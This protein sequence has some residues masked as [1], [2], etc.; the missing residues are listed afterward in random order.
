[1][2][3][4]SGRSPGSA[5]GDAGADDDASGAPRPSLGAV[6]GCDPPAGSDCRCTDEGDVVVDGNGMADPAEGTPDGTANG[7]VG[8]T[9]DGAAEGTAGDTAEGTVGDTVEGNSGGVV[10]DAA[11]ERGTVDGSEPP[12]GWV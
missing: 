12:S 10:G 4:A 9:P 2:P 1:M 3:P 11:D 5:P 6:T 8:G 7:A